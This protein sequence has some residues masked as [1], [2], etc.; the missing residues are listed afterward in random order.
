MKSF[1]KIIV[2]LFIS[3]GFITIIQS[4]KKK[5]T[6]PTLTT[7]NISGI[8]QTSAISGGNVTNNGGEDIIT[9]GVCWGIIQNPTV[10]ANETSDGKG[11]GAFISSITGLTANTNYHVRAYAT[12]SEGISYGNEVVFTTS[13]ILLATLTTTAISSIT[14]TTSVSGGNIT[15]D[16]GG[17]ITARGVCWNTSSGPTIANSKTSDGT[18]TGG[19]SSSLTGLTGNTTYYVRAYATNNAGTAY[20]NEVVFT[21]SSILL[22]TLTTTAISSITATT[23]VSGGNITDD[24]GGTITASGVCWNTSSGPTITNSKT[25]DGIS[26]GGFSSSLTGLTGNTTYYVR[27]YATNK[28]GTAYGNEISFTTSH[29]VPILTTTA[30]GSI[31]QTTASSGGNISNDG[32]A[33]ITSRGV[34]WNTSGSPTIANSETTDGTGTGSF[35]SSLTGLTTNT[36]YHVR[37]YATNSAGTSY[38]NEISFTSSSAVVPTL[39]TIAVTLIASTTASSGG[40]ISN[41]GGASVTAHGVCWNTSGVPTIA[42][43]K[44]SDGSGYGS[45]ASSLFGLTANTIY[46]VRAYATNSAGTAYGNE[47]SFITSISIGD[48]YQGGIVAYILQSGDPGYIAGQK[49]GLIA[50]PRDLSTRLMWG[51]NGITGATATALGTGKANTKTITNNQGVGSYAAWSCS[52]LLLNGYD[53]WYLPSKDELYRLYLNRVAIGG[54]VTQAGF[55]LYWSSSE[56]DSDDAWLQWFDTGLQDNLMYKGNTN[57]VRPVRSF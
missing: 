26:T 20:G 29:L 23:A 2:I 55:G 41:D 48:S 53:D 40:N 1:L 6:I 36:T 19:F 25:S 14:I 57:Y 18:S 37:A 22:S 21:T 17:T 7:E 31:T 13:S 47:I 4:C 52:I 32:G 15:D 51:S 16:G 45:F 56:V 44:T 38:G 12:N 3:A 5:T 30:I 35:T 24:G 9:R 54:F 43:S 42:N 10:S 27:A 34:C 8:T 28:G 33:S 50:A 11:N 49:H 39:S 46:Y